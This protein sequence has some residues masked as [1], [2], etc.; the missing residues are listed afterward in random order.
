MGH[1]YVKWSRLSTLYISLKETNE[2]CTLTIKTVTIQTNSNG[3][4]AVLYFST[5]ELANEVSKTSKTEFLVINISMNSVP[6]SHA[7]S[8]QTDHLFF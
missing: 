6:I 3:G 1:Y 8:R 2:Q 5:H 4:K 7:T